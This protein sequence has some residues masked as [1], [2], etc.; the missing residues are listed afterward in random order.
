VCTTSDLTAVRYEVAR[1]DVLADVAMQAFDVT[2]W[3]EADAARV[4]YV[5]HLVSAALEAAAAALLA[6]DD[7]RRAV[8]NRRAVPSGEIWNDG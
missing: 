5:A 4:A 6:V 8:G 3:R 2:I 1:A 7:M